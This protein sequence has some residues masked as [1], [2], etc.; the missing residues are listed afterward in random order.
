MRTKPHSQVGVCNLSSILG[1]Q[2]AAS[3]WSTL[4]R[5]TPC[6][7]ESAP[8]S[9]MLAKTRGLLS[10]ARPSPSPRAIANLCLAL[11]MLLC[12]LSL[13]SQVDQDIEI[14]FKP[15]GSYHG[16]D[17]DSI[18][19][20][21]NYPNIHIPLIDFPERGDISYAAII[22]YNNQGWSVFPNCNSQS[23]VCSPVWQFKGA[24]VSLDTDTPNSFG[25]AQGPLVN[26]SKILVYR[27][28]TA[29]G[30]RHLMAQI[31]SGGVETLDG[32][33]IWYDGTAFPNTGT[34]RN[35]RG[36]RSFVGA[37][38]DVNGNVFS[39]PSDAN[40]N[41]TDTLGR[42]LPNAPSGTPTADFSG[43]TG[44]LPT[45]AATIFSFPGYNGS[46]R[47]FKTC[48]VTITVQSNF[49]TSGYYNDI[50][51]PISE[52]SY[53]R[54]FIQSVVLYNGVSWASSLAWTFEYDSRNL[55]DSP[56]VNYGDLTKITLPTGGTISYT[57]GFVSP[58][59]SDNYNFPTPVRRG[60]FSRT[61]DANDGT[62][63]HTWNYT[64]SG[65]VTDPDLNDTVHTFSAFNGPCSLFE[66]KTQYFQGS[67]SSG[68]LLKTV[69]TQY[70]WV[71]DPF[72]T[73]DPNGIPAA[74]NVFPK[75]ITTT[76][77][78]G[79]VSKIEKDYDTY[80]V[81][82]DPVNGWRTGSYG[83]VIEEREFD[84]GNGT[85]GPLLRRTDYT[86][87]AFDGS[88]LASSYLSANL[89]NLV[90]SVTVYD[91]AGES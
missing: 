72:E 47:Q 20:T 49:Q 21:N 75:I 55:G 79:K 91:G 16:G 53:T 24:G 39:L 32:T 15:Y 64:N 35:V 28:G 78:S 45:Q 30:S 4:A 33:A 84:Y 14:G 12:P 34:A 61:V 29:D 85:P 90:G 18:N 43:C 17:L 62:G 11:L 82:K 36:V 40:P 51:Y 22:R 42:T 67:Q 60:V 3:S 10:G 56:S 76:W 8:V 41:Y 9:G 83:N 58:C 66:T 37:L 74:T 81:Y 86:Y 2:S 70:Q 87:R 23:G 31:Q 52:R 6:A 44:P 73:L 19:L 5:K 46:T 38:E 89:V 54:S 80:L 71:V 59:G 63:P 26:P 50:Q 69:D 48:E 13:L 88:P 57:W 68:H 27:A 77:P 25:A 7:A 65:I 1:P